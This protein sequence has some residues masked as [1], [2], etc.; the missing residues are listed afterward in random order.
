MSWYLPCNSIS[1]EKKI[2]G[3]RLSFHHSLLDASPLKISLRESCRCIPSYVAKWKAVTVMYLSY[4]NLPKKYAPQFMKASVKLYQPASHILLNGSQRLLFLSYY[5]LLLLCWDI[6]SSS[7]WQFLPSSSIAELT[8]KY[9]T[10]RDIWGKMCLKI[11][12]SYV[13]FPPTI[14]FARKSHHWIQV[15]SIFFWNLFLYPCLLACGPL[16]QITVTCRS[17]EKTLKVLLE[18]LQ[19]TFLMTCFE[20][21]YC[22]CKCCN[23]ALCFPFVQTHHPSVSSSSWVRRTMTSSTSPMT[24]SLSWTSS[25]SEMALPLNGRR[26]P[27]QDMMQAEAKRNPIA[28]L[29]FCT[30]CF[31]VIAV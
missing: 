2:P 29:T 28:L 1:L 17:D 19:G 7:V 30:F 10:T 13:Y 27:G 16:L 6:L 8:E 11:N 31:Y 21:Y 22:R 14:S 3:K 5:H 20:I 25:P 24:S 4:C 26:L 23:C 18:I 9:G 15:N 12:K